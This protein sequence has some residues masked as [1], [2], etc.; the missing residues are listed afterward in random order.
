[1]TETLPTYVVML[2]KQRE[3]V[4][5]THLPTSRRI[6]ARFRPSRAGAEYSAALQLAYQYRTCG[7]WALVVDERDLWLYEPRE[8]A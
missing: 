6:V 5:L 4:S 7:R 2:T 1:V 8:N 3:G